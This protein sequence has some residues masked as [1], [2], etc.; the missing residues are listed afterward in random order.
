MIAYPNLIVDILLGTSKVN[1]PF[2]D[3]TV[4]N[5]FPPKQEFQVINSFLDNDNNVY[6]LKTENKEQFNALEDLLNMTNKSNGI[7]LKNHYI[8]NGQYL[9]FCHKN[10]LIQLQIIVS[11][12]N[13][14]KNV[15]NV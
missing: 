6:I 3:L 9:E 4:I 13:I 11:N 5:T 14:N 2:E 10:Q 1:T 15:Y 12:K 7:M 8:A